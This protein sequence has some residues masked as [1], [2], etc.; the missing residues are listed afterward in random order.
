MSCQA[1]HPY[2]QPHVLPSAE[3]LRI[4]FGEVQGSPE[5]LLHGVRYGVLAYTKDGAQWYFSRKE[6]GQLRKK[7]SL[8]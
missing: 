6:F 1:A 4:R 8:W 3:L 5:E 2:I 7:K